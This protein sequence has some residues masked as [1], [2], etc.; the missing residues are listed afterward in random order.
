MLYPVLKMLL[1]AFL[2]IVFQEKTEPRSSVFLCLLISV[3][4]YF[5]RLKNFI[6]IFKPS[7]SKETIFL[8]DLSDLVGKLFHSIK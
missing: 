4:Y 3:S 7:N 1:R 5:S 2:T 6:G 8:I